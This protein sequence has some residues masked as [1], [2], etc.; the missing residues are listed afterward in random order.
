MGEKKVTIG[1]YRNHAATISGSGEDWQVECSCG[2]QS[3]YVRR[4]HE[5]GVEC[6]VWHFKK[7][8]Q[9]RIDA[10]VEP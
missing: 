7:M 4:T 9:R 3:G 10:G 1:R 2:Y 5:L 8:R 6:A